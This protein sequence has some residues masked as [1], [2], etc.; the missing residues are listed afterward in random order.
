M[1]FKLRPSD[2]SFYEFFTRAAAN[3]VRGTELLSELALPDTD[4]Q[5]VSERLGEVEH[6]NDEI[7]HEVFNKFKSTFITPCDRE[8][9]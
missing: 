3:L 9:I 8:D 4:M 5:S 2:N 7:T 6:D 1:R